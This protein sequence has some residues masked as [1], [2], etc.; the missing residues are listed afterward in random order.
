MRP[1]QM[2]NLCKLLS[3][4]FP[5]WSP[6]GDTIRLMYQALSDLPVEVVSKAVDEWV[7]TEERPP[8]IA[9]LRRKCA[10]VSGALPPTP[11]EAWL[12]VNEASYKYGYE[13][14]RPPWSSPL[15]REAVRTI[16]WWEIC[17]GDNSTAIRAQFLKAYESIAKKQEKQV[18]SSISFSGETSVAISHSTVVE[19][20]QT[21]RSYS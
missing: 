11:T 21:N 19:L 13:G 8:T 20:E 15:I 18:I 10:E 7:L 2:A 12:E 14:Q 5:Q 4:A 9:G 6:T 16:G 3:S 17:R 1:E